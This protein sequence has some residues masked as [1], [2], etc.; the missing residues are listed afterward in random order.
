MSLPAE[1]SGTSIGGPLG[2]NLDTGGRT[3]IEIFATCTGAAKYSLW[4]SN[5]E[6]AWRLLND[7]DVDP[8]MELTA[9][10]KVHVGLSNAYRWVSVGTNNAFN[11]FIQIV[12]S[13]AP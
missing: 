13:G 1:N 9:A 2:V 11:N 7:P 5:D 4:G 6:Y 3:H 8:I 12:A 10:G